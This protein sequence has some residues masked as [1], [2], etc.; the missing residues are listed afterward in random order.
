MV[1]QTTWFSTWSGRA[2]A[3]L[4]I[5]VWVRGNHFIALWITRIAAAWGT[6]K[7]QAVLE[8]VYPRL[9]KISVDYAVMER[10]TQDE[11]ITVC[12]IAMGV[13]WMDVGSWPSFGETLT[14]DPH[15]NRTN[16]HTTHLDSRHVLAVSDDPNHTIATVGC[17]DL[18]IVHTKDATLVCPH[19]QAQRIKELAQEVDESLQ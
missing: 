1:S 2:R 3:W 9:P 16:A 8:E 12:T 5:H 17:T 14:E 13:W 10:A 7:Q 4:N 19:S 11:R 15:G 6:S 18:V